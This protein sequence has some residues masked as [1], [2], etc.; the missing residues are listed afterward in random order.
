MC[1]HT[2][3]AGG[4]HGTQADIGI[5]RDP[6]TSADGAS[7]VTLV[8]IRDFVLLASL[9]STWKE[10]RSNKTMHVRSNYTVFAQFPNG[11]FVNDEHVGSALADG[12][13]V[14]TNFA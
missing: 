10:V 3:V 2:L 14:G 6:M 13:L 12:L 5:V 9:R 7:G 11:F 4:G 1:D 8:T